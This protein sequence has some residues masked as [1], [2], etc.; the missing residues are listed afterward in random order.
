MEHWSLKLLP[1]FITKLESMGARV[2]EPFA[3]NSSIDISSPGLANKVSRS[4]FNNLKQ[5]D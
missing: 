3:R 1:E 4:N 2:W 5:A